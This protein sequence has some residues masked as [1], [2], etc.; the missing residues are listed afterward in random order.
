MDAHEVANMDFHY[1]KQDL[2]AGE[3][4]NEKILAYKTSIDVF[5]IE[6][7]IPYAKPYTAWRKGDGDIRLAA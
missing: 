1:R 4:F 2:E 5:S 6:L 7:T 3:S